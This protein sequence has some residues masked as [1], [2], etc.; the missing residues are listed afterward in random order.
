MGTKVCPRCGESKSLAE[1]GFKN[2]A[3]GWLQ[4]WCRPCERIYKAAWYLQRREQHIARVRLERARTKQA[5]RV[6]LLAYLMEH[7]CVDCG[8]ANLVVLDLDHVRDKRKNVSSMV[9]AGFCWATIESEIAK[10]EV[11]CANCH[12]IKTAK[13]RGYYDGKANGR[14]FESPGAYMAVADN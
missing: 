14:L 4:S 10:C 11:R 9:A 2:R 8:E 7:P 12:R 3:R 5:N 1:F 6:Q 13:E